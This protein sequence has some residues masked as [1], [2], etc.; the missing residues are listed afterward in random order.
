LGLL[1]QRRCSLQRLFFGCHHHHH[2]HQIMTIKRQ[3]SN[4]Q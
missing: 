3:K 4:N 1:T 2:H